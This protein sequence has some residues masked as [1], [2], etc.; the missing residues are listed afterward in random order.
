MDTRE[1]LNQFQR[2]DKIRRNKLEEL[3]YLESIATGLSSFPYGTEKVQTSG[4]T[5]KIGDIVS[6]IVDLKVEINGVIDECLRKRIEVI[7]TIDSITNPVLYDLLFKR[8]VEGKSLS[9]I[10]DEIGY[11]SQWTRELH[12]SALAE[13]KKLKDFE[14]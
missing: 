10:A 3:K 9:V 13:V 6:K 1:Y 4:N 14:S 8:Y 7:N 11:T 2:Y 5:D 12:L